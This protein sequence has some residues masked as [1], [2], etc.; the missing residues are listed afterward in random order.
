MCFKGS[1]RC[2]ANVSVN[3][4]GAEAGTR[5]E[6]KNLNSTRFMTAALSKH[7]IS[8]RRTV[9]NCYSAFEV[10][11][12]ITLLSAGEKIPL[13]TRG[14]DEHKM[15]TYR[16][17]SKEASPDYRYMPDPNLPPLRITP[18]EFDLQFFVN[19]LPT[20]LI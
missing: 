3:R 8:T 10:E 13:E 6:I 14:F 18:V 2:D 15:Q 4:H 12:H 1:L 20:F 17:R 11:R 7:K 16:L 5:T 9:S 19:A